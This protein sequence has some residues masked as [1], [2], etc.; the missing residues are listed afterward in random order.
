M[1]VP[2]TETLV[3]SASVQACF[4]FLPS[5]LY[6]SLFW[7]QPCRECGFS[8]GIFAQRLWLFQVDRLYGASIWDIIYF[9]QGKDL[10]PCSCISTP[11]NKCTLKPTSGYYCYL[12]QHRHLSGDHSFCVGGS[13]SQQGRWLGSTTKQGLSHHP[14][15]PVVRPEA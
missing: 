15:V 4:S 8:L 13:E 9:G 1:P 14:N 11:T 12:S 2:L 7:L 5:N 6:V 3:H 10:T